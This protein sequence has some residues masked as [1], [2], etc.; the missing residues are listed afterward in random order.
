MKIVSA[1]ILASAFFTSASAF[2]TALRLGTKGQGYSLVL[3][4]N[5]EHSSDSFQSGKVKAT[6]A[7]NGTCHGSYEFNLEEGTLI[8]EF[9]SARGGGGCTNENLMILIDRESYSKVLA[10]ETVS[11]IYDSVL[12]Y[13]TK[14]QSTLSLVK[15]EA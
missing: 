13:R 11:V 9:I 12:F 6:E 8:I 10:G 15:E 2:S 5:I 14:K 7:R 4:M 1:V 3:D